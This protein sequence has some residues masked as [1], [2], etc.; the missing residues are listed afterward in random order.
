MKSWMRTCSFC[1]YSGTFDARSCVSS[2]TFGI[3][4]A[5]TPAITTKASTNTMTMARAR[6]IFR[7]TKKST[8]GDS[9]HATTAPIA[10]GHSTGLSRFST[11]PSPHTAA[12]ISAITVAMATPVRM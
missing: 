12:T 7:R 3:T 5:T 8:T 4:L 1:E 6:E 11:R 2:T 10:S 9:R